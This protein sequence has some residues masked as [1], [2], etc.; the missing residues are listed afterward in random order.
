[1]EIKMKNPELII[2]KEIYD[3]KNI[4][5]NIEISELELLCHINNENILLYLNSSTKYICNLLNKIKNNNFIIKDIKTHNH[6][7]SL[8]L[9]SK[10]Y[11]HGKLTEVYMGEK[12]IWYCRLLKKFINSEF[13][14]DKETLYNNLKEIQEYFSSK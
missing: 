1:M 8:F 2:R 13:C 4:A 6:F 12:G 14:K 7:F 11:Y 5:N 9:I 3:I 10:S